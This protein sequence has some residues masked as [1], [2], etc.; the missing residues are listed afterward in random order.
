MQKKNRQLRGRPPVFIQVKDLGS[1]KDAYI[2]CSDN[3]ISPS[4]PRLNT[5]LDQS[6]LPLEA[7]V[8]IVSFDLNKHV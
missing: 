2:N 7:A 5:F 6:M 8:G 3:Q 1:T 4:L